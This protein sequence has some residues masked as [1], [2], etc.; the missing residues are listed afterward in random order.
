MKNISTGQANMVFLQE[1]KIQKM[2]DL[3]FMSL[4]NT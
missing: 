2:S 1:T 4:W 3:F